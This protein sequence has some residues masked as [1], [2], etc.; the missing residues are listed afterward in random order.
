MLLMILREKQ[1]FLEK[2]L[3]MD[4][5]FLCCV[6]CETGVPASVDLLTLGNTLPLVSPTLLY[7]KVAY[8]RLCVP[9]Y[10][11]MV[12]LCIILYVIYTQ[13]AIV[14]VILHV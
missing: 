14:L 2:V 3:K 7:C 10:K 5:D 4:V 12:S 13:R 6:P 1:L 11:L 8:L 9:W